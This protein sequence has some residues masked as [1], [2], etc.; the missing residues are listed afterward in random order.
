MKNSTTHFHGVHWQNTKTNPNHP[1]CKNLHIIKTKHINCLQLFVWKRHLYSTSY[2]TEDK[3]TE[4][5]NNKNKTVKQLH[6]N[7]QNSCSCSMKYSTKEKC[8]QALW[9]STTGV[10]VKLFSNKYQLTATVLTQIS[11]T[12]VK[13]PPQRKKSAFW[14]MCVLCSLKSKND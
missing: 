6:Y 8:F 14:H 12:V 5:Y 2:P 1:S 7:T 11:F 10:Y 3:L 9:L 13:H 4:L